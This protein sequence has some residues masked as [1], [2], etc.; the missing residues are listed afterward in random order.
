M[1]SESCCF[2][3]KLG[4]KFKGEEQASGLQ[5]KSQVGGRT[6]NGRTQSKSD[7]IAGII[8]EVEARP[9]HNNEFEGGSSF[10]TA[11]PHLHIWCRRYHLVVDLLQPDETV[12]TITLK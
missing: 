9:S 10:G 8:V 4:T 6:S 12:V 5:T 3:F 11:D 2:S 1:Q 7:V